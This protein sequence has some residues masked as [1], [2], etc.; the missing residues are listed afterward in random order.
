MT[1]I[2]SLSALT[3]AD[4]GDTL[5]IVD[6][7]ATTTKKITKSQFLSDVVDGTLISD[8]AIKAEHVDIS[9]A[10]QTARDAL[11]EFEGMMVWREDTN[12]IEAY[13]G[14]AWRS[15]GI[16]EVLGKTT[17]TSAGDTISCSSLPARNHLRLLISC[18]NSG[19]IAARL[20]FN[21]DTGTNYAY[22]ASYTGGAFGNNPSIAFFALQPATVAEA[23]PC[24]VTV[25]IWNPSGVFKIITAESNDAY[26]T[27]ATTTTNFATYV[28]KWASTSQ[29]SKVTITNVGAG[30]FTSGS[31][32]IVLGS[33]F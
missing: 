9:V 31:E 27:D 17:L 19:A 5:P 18:K 8:Q 33:D 32:L 28:G 13:D 14:S 6:V 25:D 22:Q 29:I 7:S 16:W 2:S 30:D 23:Y 26:G 10:D 4:S 3:A 15:Y 12:R 20:N 21:D 24:H 11:T 1:R